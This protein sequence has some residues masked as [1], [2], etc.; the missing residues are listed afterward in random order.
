[1]I[2]LPI[3]SKECIEKKRREAER[4]VSAKSIAKITDMSEKKAKAAETHLEIECVK[5]MLPLVSHPDA[6]QSP[7]A[8]YLQLLQRETLDNLRNSLS[9]SGP[10]TGNKSSRTSIST[11][12]F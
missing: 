9:L 2:S 3:G 8:E 10:R 4:Y 5:H 7:K 11:R 6:G 1:M 12:A